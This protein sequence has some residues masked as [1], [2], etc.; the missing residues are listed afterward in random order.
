MAESIGTIF[1]ELDLDDTPY[2]KAQDKLYDKVSSTAKNIEQN[3]KNL[4]DK[5]ASAFENMQ[6]G[7]SDQFDKLKDS[8]MAAAAAIAG[9]MK[10]VF[11]GIGNDIKDAFG[12]GWDKVKDFFVNVGNQ[13][14]TL[15]ERIAAVWVVTKIWGEV[16][17]SV[18]GTIFNWV[19]VLIIAWKSLNFIIGLFTGKS[20]QSDHIDALI[21]ETKAVEEL[22][23][24]LQLSTRDAQSYKAAMDRL[25]IGQD[26]ITAVF[27]GYRTALRDNRDEMDRLGVK[28]QDTNGKI[29]DQRT[30]LENAKK[31]LDQYT[32][33][34]DR[35]QAATAIG[36]GSY[37][38]INNYLKITQAEL[39]RSRESLD[40]YHL[41]IGPETQKAVNEYTAAMLEFRAESKLMAD[42]ISRAIADQIMPAFTSLAKW[43]SGGWPI[44][45]D[46]FRYSM[47]QITTLL[48]GL[49]MSFDLVVDA[50]KGAAGVLSD[51]FMGLATAAARALTGDF[52]GAKD[53]LV[54][55]WE[56]ASKRVSKTWQEMVADANKASA[57]M[58]L[59]WG[60]DDRTSS[61][62]AAPKQGKTWQPAPEKSTE[63]ATDQSN[64]I[65]QALSMENKRLY[66]AE[67]E[68][69]DHLAKIRKLNGEDE[70]NFFNEVINQKE[71]ALNKWFDEQEKIII[72]TTKDEELYNA[73]IGA[74]NAE[75]NKQW[76]K[77][78]DKRQETTLEKLNNQTKAYAD[79]YQ[80]LTGYEDQ[81]RKNIFDW[82]DG[83]QKRK[84]AFYKDEVAAAKRAADLKGKIEY[85][86]FKKKTDYIA[87]GLSQL[88]ESFQAMASIYAEGSSEAKRWEDAAHAL[89]I[90]QRAVAVVQAVGAIATQG[91]GNPYTAFYRVAAMSATMIALLASIGESVNGSSTSSS[92]PY[93]ATNTATAL[94]STEG[95][96]SVSN[97]LELL[98]DTYEMEYRELSGI[99]KEMRSL[100]A[101]ITGLVT[102][103]VRT[104]GVSSFVSVPEGYAGWQEA[105]FIKNMEYF[106]QAVNFGPTMLD[107]IFK[108]GGANIL[109]GINT[110]ISKGVGWVL[111]GLFGGKTSYE[112]SG[113]GIDV[114]GRSVS[115][116]LGGAMVDGMYYNI[117][118][119]T[120]DGGFFKKDQVSY[121]KY[122]QA[123]GGDTTQMFTSIYKDLGKTMVAIAAGLGADM[124]KTLN[125]TFSGFTLELKG[126]TADEISKAISSAV[127]AIG[128]TAVSYLFGDIL[129]QYQ[130]VNEG[131]LETATRIIQDRATIEYWLEKTGQS[132]NTTTTQAIAFSEALIDIAGSLQDLTDAMQTYYD[133]FF[134]DAEKESKLKADLMSGLGTYGYDLPGSRAGYRALVESLNLTTA[135][136]QAAY[137]ALMQMAESADQYYS[138]LEDAKSRLSESSYA[139]KADYMRA[140]SGFADG[141][142]STGPNSGYLAEL[143]GTEL[144]VSPRN[145]YPARV[146]GADSTEL[147]AKIDQLIEEVRAGNY[148][149]AKN[150]LKMVRSLDLLEQE[151]KTEGVLT[152]TS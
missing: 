27:E 23:A 120:V 14:K 148:S 42:G 68:L 136:G 125:Y 38:Q 91:L 35:N 83:E 43:F 4:A 2:K 52:A 3:Y 139:T 98:K 101:N 145:A 47:A 146:V 89:E 97:S 34:W 82:I 109:G 84:A 137:V 138:Y 141:G 129:S 56:N 133:R 132:F 44:I 20:Y 130:K 86:L 46:I 71:A 66:D 50:I 8:S 112:L 29:L 31:V 41:G 143:H 39:A 93:A 61:A 54:E 55:G 40:I 67:I 152:R 26:S 118:K 5:T 126:L 6:K 25:G 11:V 95:S 142:I 36:M 76:Q 59:A 70:L 22:R 37:D 60:F 96:Q 147:A 94:G 65:Y 119:K 12:S 79:F 85:D 115:D 106:N 77:Y 149:N 127:S 33:G 80:E 123:L 62:K 92:S 116:L 19:A 32:E 144:V 150:G 111:G 113:A 88:Q 18:L 63:T 107:K 30:T 117:I 105:G 28:Y 24:Q 74:I 135:A 53:A 103:I 1:A 17:G 124:Q 121:Q 110:A 16:A 13:I 58:R 45:V 99:Y 15:A 81:Y 10:R 104:G 102:S 73:R 9:Y 114:N 108:S 134:T 151:M 75:Y 48:W 21:E 90:A 78:E 69:Q 51:I 100:N 131:L 72:K 128:D 57:A 49:K 122:T 64:R 140:I 87:Q 7:V